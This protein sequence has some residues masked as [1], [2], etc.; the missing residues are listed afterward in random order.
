MGIIDDG[1]DAPI[2]FRRP[3]AIHYKIDTQLEV[4]VDLLDSEGRFNPALGLRPGGATGALR[5]QKVFNLDAVEGQCQLQVLVV[6]R[7]SSLRPAPVDRE[8]LQKHCVS[9]GLP[10]SNRGH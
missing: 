10:G 2:R 3:A 8:W 7:P 1:E 5:V 6:A 4:V 9:G